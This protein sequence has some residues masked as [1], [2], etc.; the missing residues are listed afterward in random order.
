MRSLV[1]IL[2]PLTL[3]AA[4]ATAAFAAQPAAP[5]ASGNSSV[6]ASMAPAASPLGP[7]LAAAASGRV[8][9]S[10]PGQSPESWS[11]VKR[12]DRLAPTGLVRSGPRGRA[13]LTRGN[14]IL[15]VDPNSELVLPEGGAME[16]LRQ[17]RG[18]V[19]YEVHREPDVHF[20]VVTPYLVA[21]VKGT[22]FG[23]MV[24]D[25]YTSVTV[26]RGH[27]EVQATMTSEKVDLFTG[28]MAVLNGPTGR[29]EVHRDPHD[30]IEGAKMEEGDAA[31][32]SRK[33][34]GK[35]V[36]LAT[37]DDLG[38]EVLYDF[39]KRDFVYF[40][41]AEWKQLGDELDA[42]FTETLD[43]AWGDE[44]R[45]DGL[46]DETKDLL[47]IEDRQNDTTS[48]SSSGNSGGLLG[49]ILP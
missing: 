3:T 40:D 13:T 45:L 7:W 22:V 38:E 16:A 12:G 6:A 14:D 29:L 49:G 4:L 1:P 41:N 37:E 18:N 42:T 34:S 9:A 31:R 19:L 25:D 48:A 15:R 30:R 33:D 46:L 24:Q 28:D 10:S 26:S 11:P 44:S 17:N 20:Q 36:R 21:G 32:R 23:V 5:A 8:E 35:M 27:V 43:L 47:G 2:T 39:S